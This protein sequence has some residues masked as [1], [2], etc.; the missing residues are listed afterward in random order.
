MRGSG[1]Q[2]VT[3]MNRPAK[4]EMAL[5]EAVAVPPLDEERLLALGRL[6]DIGCRLRT[7]TG[8]GPSTVGLVEIGQAIENE[9]CRL[10]G[11]PVGQL[12]ARAERFTLL[13]EVFQPTTKLWSCQLDAPR[14]KVVSC[15]LDAPSRDAAIAGGLV[16]MARELLDRLGKG[17][18]VTTP[19]VVLSNGLRECMEGY[20]GNLASVHEAQ[21]MSCHGLEHEDD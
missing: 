14:E 11:L 17:S 18:D 12:D 9:A 10:A 19:E 6:L 21:E 4:F 8:S 20:E 13:V 1:G 5:R 16:G 3:A 7:T 15:H 2:G